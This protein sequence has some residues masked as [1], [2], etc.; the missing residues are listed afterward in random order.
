MKKSQDPEIQFRTAFLLLEH[1]KSG[2]TSRYFKLCFGY[3]TYLKKKI[4][5]HLKNTLFLKHL[6]IPNWKSSN[7]SVTTTQIGGMNSYIVWCYADSVN[8]YVTI[9][10][11]GSSYIAEIQF[12]AIYKLHNAKLNDLLKVNLFAIS[13]HSISG[14]RSRRRWLADR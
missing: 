4:R 3:S 13:I 14:D 6:Q 8:L 1:P 9:P 12:F 2:K 7:R 10:P 5:K 11:I